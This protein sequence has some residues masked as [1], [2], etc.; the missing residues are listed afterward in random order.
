MKKITAMLILVLSMLLLTGCGREKVPFT[1]K[2]YEAAQVTSVTVDVR[3]RE[4]RVEKSQDDKVHINYFDSEKEFFEIRLEEGRLTM[5][6]SAA[7]EWKDYVG[8]NAPREHR[9]ITLSL[10]ETLLE[11]LNLSTTHEGISLCPLTAGA[12]SLSANG[13][14][15]DFEELGV[16]TSLKLDVKNGH[17]SGSLLGGYDDFDITCTTKKGDCNLPQRKE[18]GDKTLTVNANN[19]NVNVELK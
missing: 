15:I 19:G 4:I 2:S 16:E 7:K 13:G 12:V 10:P 9:I 18:G 6:I 14:S 17:I 3:G 11:S 5:T 8:K 1:A